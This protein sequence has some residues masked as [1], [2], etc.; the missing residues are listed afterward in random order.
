VDVPI[1]D[2]R[3][4]EGAA[5]PQIPEWRSL[6]RD[7]ELDEHLRAF[8]A[9][10][11]IIVKEL[12]LGDGS[13]GMSLGG[14]ITLDPNAGVKTF[15]H[16]LIHE[17]LPHRDSWLPAAVR[18]WQAEIGAYLVCTRLGVPDLNCPMYLAS[19]TASGKQVRKQFEIAAKPAHQIITFVEA[20][21]GL[22]AGVTDAV[23]DVAGDGD[24]A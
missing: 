23:R 21:L 15:V 19:W 17:L 14:L 12:A 24:E 3:H 20:R 13:Q 9:T 4:T 1:Y 5:L 11:N 18:E 10:H 8:A 6:A 16:E 2:V 7:A 22:S